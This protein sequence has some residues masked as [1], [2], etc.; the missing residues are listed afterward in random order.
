[1]HFPDNDNVDGDDGGGGDD[2]NSDDDNGGGDCNNDDADAGK[3]TEQYR[4]TVELLTKMSGLS[5]RAAKLASARGDTQM[6]SQLQHNAKVRPGAV[7]YT[8]LTLPTKLS[9]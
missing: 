5:A 3:Q 8:H 9:V 4:T 7:S 2:F 6:E 1:M